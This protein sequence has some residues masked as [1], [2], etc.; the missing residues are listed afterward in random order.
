[1]DSLQEILSLQRDDGGF[2]LGMPLKTNARV[3]QSEIEHV[4]EKLEINVREFRKCHEYWQEMLLNVRKWAIMDVQRWVNILKE[5]IP[6]YSNESA[7]KKAVMLGR[8]IQR[9]SEAVE[10]QIEQ[11]SKMI[12]GH[13]QDLTGDIESRIREID[14][15]RIVATMLALHL[16]ES[17]FD[18]RR[19]EWEGMEQKSRCWLQD[20]MSRVGIIMDPKVLEYDVMECIKDTSYF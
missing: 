8:D 4:A 3:S 2:D 6:I 12:C 5:T 10:V 20:Q 11:F 19:P 15:L 16:L 17:R 9:F 18:N 13:V 14:S 7:N 1:M